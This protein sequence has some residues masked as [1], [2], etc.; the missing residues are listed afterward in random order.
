[1]GRK[2]IISGA[3]FL[4][5]A[6]RR[7]LTAGVWCRGRSGGASWNSTAVLCIHELHEMPAEQRLD[8][9]GPF[10]NDIFGIYVGIAR[11]VG[12]PKMEHLF[13]PAFRIASTVV[14]V[15]SYEWTA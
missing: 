10:V 11:L 1:M 6:P 2:W 13:R 5:W 9:V 8:T 14:M 12:I 7:L 15:P 4:V 3:F